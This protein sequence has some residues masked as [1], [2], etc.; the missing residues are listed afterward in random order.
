MDELLLRLAPG[1][2]LLICSFAGRNKIG[3][4]DALLIIATGYGLG[5]Y[6]NLFVICI[7]FILGGIWGSVK[8]ILKRND[9]SIAFAP[10]MLAGCISLGVLK[11]II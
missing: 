6:N 1:I 7:A 5:A 3:E 8:M 10:F 2:F 11:L 9:R 4:G